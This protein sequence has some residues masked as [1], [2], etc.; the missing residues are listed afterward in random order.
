MKRILCIKTVHHY[1]ES[2][3]TS[4]IGEYTDKYD[5]FYFDR[6][7]GKMLKTLERDRS[8]EV[9]SPGRE[10]RYFIPY[11]GGETPGTQLYIQY[12]KQDL[13]RMEGLHKGDWT[14]IGIKAEA[15]VQLDGE[16]IQK[17]TSTGL[18]GI[19]SD[20]GSPYLEEVEK[21]E[22]SSLQDELLAAGFKLHQIEAVEVERAD[23]YE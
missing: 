22:L 7:Q 20:G 17:L 1:D 6:E 3:D 8:Y 23:G 16:I 21:E 18:W 13:A 15:R 2:P 19:E 12:G 9:P 5:P 11:A 14:F 10:Y 4:C